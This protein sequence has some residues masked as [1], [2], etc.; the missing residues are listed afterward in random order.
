M[1]EQ[2][3]ILN[4]EKEKTTF[5]SLGLRVLQLNSRRY[6]R[7]LMH[8]YH[9]IKKE[10]LKLLEPQGYIE[11]KPDTELGYYGSI[12]SIYKKGKKRF[13]VQW[14][15]EEGFGSVEFWSNDTWT[16]LKT[17][18]PESTETEFKNNITVLCSEL[19]LQL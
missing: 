8:E 6:T 9:K 13:M 5:P 1:F 18:V 19:E 15:G 12:H 14:D 4:Q 11:T 3:S 2:T 10:V 16:M 7:Q 17:I